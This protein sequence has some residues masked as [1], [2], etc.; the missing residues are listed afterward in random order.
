VPD[1]NVYL[2]AHYRTVDE[3]QPPGNGTVKT[4]GTGAALITFNIGDA[5]AGF[6]VNVDVTALVDGQ[7]VAFQTSFTPQ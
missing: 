1:A 3:R 2:V 4:D 6:Q 5:T 7:Q